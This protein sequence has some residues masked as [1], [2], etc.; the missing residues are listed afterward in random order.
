M[1][2]LVDRGGCM[3]KEVRLILATEEDAPLLH[4]IKY[5]SFLSIYEKYK[6]E[7]TSPV[8]ESIEKVIKCIQ[9]EKS[10][11]YIIQFHD[12]SVGG[13][14]VVERQSG[15]FHIGPIFILP[16]FQNQGI[17]FRV[18]NLI[19]NAYPQAITW[20]LNTIL[21]E[22]GNCYFYEKCGF[23]KTGK[24]KA[25]TK[26]MTLVDYE[27]CLVTI[28][29]FQETDAEEV[30][31]LIIRNFKEV[32]SRDYSPEAIDNLVKSHDAV[33]VKGVASYANMYVFRFEEK[34]IGVGSISS[35][36]GSETESI[37]LTIFVL[38]EFHGKGIGRTIIRTLEQD[39][40]FKRAVRVEIPASITA[41]E[42]YQKFGYEFK[43]GVKQLDEEG[44]YRLEKL[45]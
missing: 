27:K 32:N 35:Y 30:A 43:Q 41:V 19:F 8:K 28:G 10:D 21:E 26:S 33:W 39:E 44:L 13:V 3:E 36:W 45:R 7:E 12:E 31:N 22:E 18:M 11:Y 6:D 5:V 1:N 38:P 20:I 4:Q 2:E 34:I 14:R 16:E 9:L 15:L 25:N 37:L 24:S 29:R 17:G 40:L 23:V 42:F